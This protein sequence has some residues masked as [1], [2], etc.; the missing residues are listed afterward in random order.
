MQIVSNQYE[1]KLQE[2]AAELEASK[3]S[4]SQ[5]DGYYNEIVMQVII[6]HLYDDVY[7]QFLHSFTVMISMIKYECMIKYFHAIVDL[8]ISCVSCHS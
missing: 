3:A 1:A 8:Y 6:L 7:I 2:L 4:H 5:L